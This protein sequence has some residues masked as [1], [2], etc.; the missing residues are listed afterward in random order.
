MGK[1]KWNSIT[2]QNW[3]TVSP[4][5]GT[6]TNETDSITIIIDRTG[7]AENTFKETIRITSVIGTDIIQDTI[8]VYLNGV[9]DQDL[10]L[11]IIS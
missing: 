4:P 3:I 11:L 10:K 1:L 8:G 6:V 2:S 7:L 9:M 5:S